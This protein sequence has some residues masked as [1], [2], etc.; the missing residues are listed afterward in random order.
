MD[1]IN[2]LREL[3]PDAVLFDDYDAAIV[4]MVHMNSTEGDADAPP[5]VVAL[6]SYERL[7]AITMHNMKEN[8]TYEGMED[9][10]TAAME[11][12]DFNISGFWY[13]ANTPVIMSMENRY[14][15]HKQDE[16]LQEGIPAADSEGGTPSPNGAPESP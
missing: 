14:A 4:G 2:L 7:V 16:T 11:Y 10:F 3:N 15:L 5:R 6:Y 8:N 12:V 13:G 1:W 9:V